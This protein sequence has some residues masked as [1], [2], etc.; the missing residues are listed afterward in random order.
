[1]KGYNARQLRKEFPK[2][3]LKAALTG[4]SRSSKTQAQWTDVMATADHEVPTWMKT[5][6]T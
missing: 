3:G 1:L 6:T 5:L 2:D 4:Y